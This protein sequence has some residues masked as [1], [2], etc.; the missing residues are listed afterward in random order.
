MSERPVGLV[1]TTVPVSQCAPVMEWVQET[2]PSFR[3]RGRHGI[4][5]VLCQS[6]GLHYM[7]IGDRHSS[8]HL[9]YL[10]LK[11]ELKLRV[12]GLNELFIK[13]VAGV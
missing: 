12:R 8:C 7:L 9:C 2:Q 3:R 4:G 6:G 1:I 13:Y 11:K 5:C 10:H